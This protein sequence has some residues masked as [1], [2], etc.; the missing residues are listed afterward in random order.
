[1]TPYQHIKDIL[2]KNNTP[3]GTELHVNIPLGN[4]SGF[5][6]QLHNTSLKTA[7]DKL[8]LAGLQSQFKELETVDGPW[9][10]W[11]LQTPYL[12]EPC[13]GETHLKEKATHNAFT[14]LLSGKKIERTTMK[15]SHQREGKYWSYSMARA[16]LMVSGKD[17]ERLCSTLSRLE[18]PFCM[19]ET[20]SN[21]NKQN[22]IKAPVEG[23][24]VLWLDRLTRSMATTLRGKGLTK[25]DLATSCKRSFNWTTQDIEQMKNFAQT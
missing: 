14:F 4:P 17:F 9:H 6:I 13:V 25:K 12:F 16:K 8:Q 2:K 11:L 15:I 5:S 19:W 20:N 1:M 22:L 21:Q 18:G 23:P 7:H 24:Y 3:E 10:N